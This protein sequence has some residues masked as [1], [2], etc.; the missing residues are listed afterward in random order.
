MSINWKVRVKNKAFWL[1][2]V[3]ALILLVQAVGAPLG[4]VWDFGT[5]GNQLAAVVEAVFGVLVL[6]G[7]VNDPTTEGIGD[8][9]RALTYSTP[10]E[11]RHGDHMRED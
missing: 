7:V 6:V 8:S 2:L 3:P 11:A 1:A 9:E 5:L 10:Y 4:Y